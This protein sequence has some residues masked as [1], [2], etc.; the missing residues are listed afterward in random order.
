M[1]RKKANKKHKFDP[2]SK[3]SRI[4]KRRKA[5]KAQKQEK[6][7]LVGVEEPKAKEE[8]PFVS[9]EYGR[10]RDLEAFRRGMIELDDEDWE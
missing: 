8:K 6:S 3:T 4:V 5:A 2:W 1:T 9:E 7:L 10:M